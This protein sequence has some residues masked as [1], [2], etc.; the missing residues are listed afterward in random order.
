MEVSDKGEILV[1]VVTSW[2]PHHLLPDTRISKAK[3]NIG[4]RFNDTSLKEDSKGQHSGKICIPRRCARRALCT[5]PERL[6]PCTAH[7]VG[8]CLRHPV[9]QGL[10]QGISHQPMPGGDFSIQ[11]QSSGSFFY[12]FLP[13]ATYCCQQTCLFGYLWKVNHSTGITEAAETGC[14]PQLV[15][16]KCH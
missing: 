15:L 2:E 9:S 3:E 13:L 12:S 4:T 8:T 16:G 6:C 10:S 7:P 1:A 5:L 14:C 11:S